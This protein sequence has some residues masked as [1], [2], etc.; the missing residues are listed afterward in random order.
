MVR[1]AHIRRS[2]LPGQDIF[3][4]LQRKR[5]G[6]RGGQAFAPLFEPLEPISGTEIHQRQPHI[7]DFDLLSAQRGQRPVDAVL[8][9]SGHVHGF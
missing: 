5:R 1:D 4:A 8:D 9:R 6:T 3:T 2:V 7:A